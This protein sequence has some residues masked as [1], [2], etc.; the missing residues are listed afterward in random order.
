MEVEITTANDYSLWIDSYD[1]GIITLNKT[2]YSEPIRI[3]HQK[4]IPITKDFSQ[5]TLEDFLTTTSQ[6][7]IVLLGTGK[8][9]L[10]LPPQLQVMLFQRGI[11]VELMSTSAAV[12]T[13]N[14]LMADSRKVSAWLWPV[15][16]T[17]LTLP[18]SD[19]V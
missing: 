16:Y 9:R 2:P 12:H 14:L 1:K 6:S 13:F 8:Q 18:T 11:A 10:F 4:V 7:E 17:H 3:S 15:S 19:L 5:L